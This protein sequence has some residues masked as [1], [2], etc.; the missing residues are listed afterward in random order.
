MVSILE[1]VKRGVVV[2]D[3]GYLLELERRGYV[4]SGSD[5]EKVGTGKG[6]GQYTPEVAIEAP[7]ALR[8]LHREFL[9]AGAQVLQALTFFG[10]REKLGRAG[11][12][13]QTEAINTA[14]VRLAR[15]VAGDS[16]LVAGSVSRT[17]L[18]EREG[19]ST[20]AHVRDLLN[21]QIQLLKAAGVD[22]LILETFFHLEEMRI[23]LECA[24]ASGLPVM[25]TMSFRPTTERCSDGH[26]PA[27]C[28]RQM[29]GGGAALVGANCEQ[30]PARMLPI[31]RA[32]REAVGG[33]VGIAAQPA[34]F[35][36]TDPTPCF[37]KL[38]QFPARL[39]YVRPARQ[40]RRDQL[41][42]RLLRLQRRLP[43]GSGS[44]CRRPARCFR[45]SMMHVTVYPSAGEA[46]RAAAEVLA[47]WLADAR[48]LVVAGG[49]SP[50]ELYRLVAL[51]RS[52]LGRFS[53]F[54]LDEYLGV[55]VEHPG[56]CA[57][58]LRREVADAWGIPAERFHGLSSRRE[59]GLASIAEHER[60]LA[61][62]GGIDA[63]VLGLGR[64]GHLGF[65]EPGS[66]SDSPGRVVDL[67]PTSISANAE[68]FGGAHAPAHGVT[69]GLGTL[70]AARRVLL[71]AFGSAKADAVY[72]TVAAAPNESCP[73]SWLQGHPEAHLFLDSA[74]A[75]R[76]PSSSYRRVE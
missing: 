62:L 10:T 45:G 57:N 38:P 35:R 16:A 71:V 42:R 12:G 25:A 39:P 40:A 60:K 4:D 14:A 17:Q 1:R 41:C 56:T 28:A 20:A 73:G 33:R 76:L 43:A 70:L 15:E 47:G 7:D 23:G 64:N 36:T 32:M 48:T 65:N 13:E 9:A 26:T 50:R 22:F 29:A 59:D 46:S 2:G 44:G 72:N 51:R 52:T 6:S 63:V 68:W 75:S 8:G 67:T 34:A 69:L 58:Q 49:N 31:L 11:F 37:T 55:P 53:V 30:E 5:R 24:A 27:E 54:T 74:A 61:A 3:G 66:P 19:P 18:F 21:E